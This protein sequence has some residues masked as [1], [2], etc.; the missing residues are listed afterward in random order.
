LRPLAVGEHGPL[1]AAGSDEQGVYSD[2]HGGFLAPE[3]LLGPVKRV[4]LGADPM[5]AVTPITMTA[6]RVK[7]PARVDKNHTTS[8]TGGIRILRTPETVDAVTQRGELEQIGLEALSAVGLTF[9]SDRVTDGAAPMFDEWLAR[10]YEDAFLDLARTE[11]L[12]GTGVGE[13]L[14]V[15]KSPCLITVAKETGQAAD[16]IKKENID[17]MEARCWDYSR[18]TWVANYDTRPQLKSIVQVVGTGGSGVP[19]LTCEGDQELLDGRPILFTDIVKTGGDL[20][21]LVLGVWS[22]YIDGTYMPL[23]LAASMHVRFIAGETAFRAWSRCDFRPWWTSP[24]TPR[25]GSLTVSPFV[26]LAE[27]A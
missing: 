9:A 15:M 25:Y 21:D 3:A 20:G 6:P 12:F 7:I 27:R 8:V 1:A 11:R 18:A 19:Y 2:P 16:T 4:P 24:L 13:G 26:T 5:A 10:C 23:T 17:K 14:G 22:E